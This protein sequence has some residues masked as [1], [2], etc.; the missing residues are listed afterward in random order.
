M[1]KGQ[2]T[3][4]ELLPLRDLPTG[5]IK[6]N[7]DAPVKTGHVQHKFLAWDGEAVEEF[8][9]DSNGETVKRSV[10][11]LLGCSSGDY[12]QSRFLSTT[13]MLEIVLRVG[14]DHKGAHHIGF[15]F[16]YDVNNIL[17]DLPWPVLVVLKERGKV[18]WNGYHIEHIPHKI[19]SVSKEGSKNRVRIED[20]FSY[21][22]TRYSTALS[23]YNIGSEQQRANISSGKADRGHFKYS[24]IDQIRRYMFD[25]LDTMPLLMEKI[26]EACYAA[27]MYIK[28]WYGPG[29]LAKYELGK[30]HMRDHMERTPDSMLL[31]VRT[32]YAGGW[33]ERYR[34][35]MYLGPVYTAD[36]NSAYAYAMAMMPSLKGKRW[37]YV[38]GEAARNYT[39]K[40]GIFRIT[41]RGDK[42]QQ[43]NDYLR[44]CHG[45]PLPLFQ[46]GRNGDI[47]R[48]F[49]TTGWWWNFEARQVRNVS[50]AEFHECWYLEDDTERP[51][52]WIADMYDARLILK[53]AGDPA[54]L[55]L[56]WAMA[57]MY[58]TVAQRTGWD[59]RKRTAP[60]WHQLEWAGAITSACRSLISQAAFPVALNGGLVSIDTDGIISTSPFGTMPDGT[61]RPLPGGT[62]TGLGQWEC[63]EYSGIIYIQNG[64]YWLRDMQG[65]WI[66]PKTRGIPMGQVEDPSIA[67]DA[68]SGDGRIRLSRHNFVGYGSAIHRRERGAWRT[69]EDSTYDIDINYTGSRQH[70]RKLCR[71]CAMGL[72]MTEALHDLAMV[73]PTDSASSPHRLPWLE[74][75]DTDAL[76]ERVRHE[77]ALHDINGEF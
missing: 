15:A 30:H 23:K 45:I 20:I 41:Y 13:D 37:V 44:A 3:T 7:G 40:F 18:K 77:W 69:W 67:T 53:S 60:R 56:K 5:E 76:A 70:V 42:V 4:K 55:A 49:N 6:V 12:V 47:T 1:P 35:G 36:L 73:P 25:E 54:Q 52:E 33:F 66:P 11:C 65:N 27:G 48:P 28:Q 72:D 50:R 17:K 19:F 8:V 63:E 38:S 43:W 26:R 31:A 9:T 64:I 39:N 59:R 68:L 10:Y 21:F 74:D 57:S 14:A 32:A 75:D 16:D 71:P 2:L 62:G 46:R 61:K 22:R 34:A 24:A 29:A 58:G 51:F